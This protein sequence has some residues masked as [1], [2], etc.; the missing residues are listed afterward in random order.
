MGAATACV[1]VRPALHA[2]NYAW[3]YN[4]SVC[5]SRQTHIKAGQGR[6]RGNLIQQTQPH[7]SRHV[8][9]AKYLGTATHKAVT[10]LFGKSFPSAL[11][12]L[13]LRP[14]SA[15]PAPAPAGLSMPA[16]PPPLFFF[17]LVLGCP[18]ASLARLLLHLLLLVGWVGLHHPDVAAAVAACRRDGCSAGRG[19]KGEG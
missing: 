14:A 19:G 18:L 13:E 5:V 17:F 10:L 11:Q 3:L 1:G 9:I 8:G 2:V 15:A 16:Q 6:W 4:R 7:N 12:A